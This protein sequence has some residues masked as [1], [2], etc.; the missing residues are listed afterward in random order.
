M[1]ENVIPFSP[2]RGNE[3]LRKELDYRQQ[4]VMIAKVTELVEQILTTLQV[5]WRRDSAMKETPTRVARM[6]VQEL[7]VGRF[8]KE[9]DLTD[10]DNEGPYDQLLTIRQIPVRTVCAHHML[11]IVGTCHIGVLYGNKSQLLGLSKY[12]RIVEFFC[13]R[14]QTQEELTRQIVT[15]VEGKVKPDWVGVRIEAAHMCM[16]FRGV[17]AASSIAVTTQIGG[18]QKGDASLKE[19]FLLECSRVSVSTGIG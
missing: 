5:D 2:V 1:A 4:S 13:R 8:A 6:W 14:F 16:A 15:F 19:E 3:R 7:M 17:E 10:F 12:H 9:P 18:H 11:P